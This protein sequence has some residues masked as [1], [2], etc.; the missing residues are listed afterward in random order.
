[1][2]KITSITISFKDG[3]EHVFEDEEAQLFTEAIVKL[4]DEHTKK[5]AEVKKAFD[6]LMGALKGV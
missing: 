4:W 3:A 1:M 6:S 2:K 5:E